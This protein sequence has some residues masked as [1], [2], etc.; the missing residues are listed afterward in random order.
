M[1][2]LAAFMGAVLVE[3]LGLYKE[4]KVITIHH[5]TLFKKF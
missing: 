1:K 4:N 2:S 3:V 5:I